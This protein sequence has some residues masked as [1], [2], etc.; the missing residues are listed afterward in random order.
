M[1]LLPKDMLILPP[2]DDR[3]FKVIMTS[4]EAKPVLIFVSEGIIESR[5]KDVQIRNTE[6]PISDI[7]EKTQQFDVNCLIDDKTQVDIEMQ[8]SRMKE[9]AG[10]DHGQLRARSIYS[11]CDLHASQSSKGVEYDRLRRTYQVM[12]CAFPVFKGH[13]ELIYRFSMRHDTNNWL[14]HNAIQS[15]FVDLTKL[16]DIVKKPTEQMSDMECLSVFLRYADNPDYRDTVNRVIEAREA[17]A[18][19]GEI[20]MSV[21]KDEHE[22]AILHSR[23]MAQMDVES[24]LLTAERIGRTEERFKIA[25]NALQMNISIDEIS[26]LTG[27]TSEE[28]EQ[29]RINI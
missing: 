20:L 21:S 25:R 2:Y 26:K 24:N 27:L 1:G 22:R 6:L 23:R 17:L 10:S 14:L 7:K 18:V 28:V 9:E 3:L 11:L 19:A 5:V 16:D 12:F 13:S 4:P 8:A 29:T 15:V